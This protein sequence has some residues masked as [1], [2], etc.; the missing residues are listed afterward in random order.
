V[1]SY[2][3]I[4]YHPADM[5]LQPRQE[6]IRQLT[7]IS[8]IGDIGIDVFRNGTIPILLA[9]CFSLRAPW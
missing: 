5:V 8:D 3:L 1:S 2:S 4:D 9:P 7:V 6:C